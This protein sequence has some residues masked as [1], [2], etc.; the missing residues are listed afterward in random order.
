MTMLQEIVTE[1]TPLRLPVPNSWYALAFSDELP[2]GQVITRRLVGEDVVLYRTQSGQASA[3]NP[4]CPHLGAHL[5]FGGAV[6][7][8]E[9]RCPFHGFRFDLDGTCTATGYGTKPP[10]RAR[11]RLWHLREVN[12]ILFVWYDSQGRP[13]AW[14]IPALDTDGWTQTRHRAFELKDHPQET[15]ENGVDIGHF[16]IVHG[17]SAVEMRSDLVLDG[18]SFQIA[19]AA[20]RPMPVFGRFGAHVDFEFDLNIHG[21]GYSLVKVSVPR[22]NVQTRLFILATPTEQERI[23]LHLA[24][25]MKKLT[26]G[27]QIHPLLFFLPGGWLSGIIGRIVHLSLIH[28]AQQDFAIWENKRYLHPPALAEGDGPIGKFRQWAKQFYHESP[29]TADNGHS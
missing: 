28:D 11:L 17:Y 15:V 9:I 22:Y 4:F 5:G 18:T 23:H 12:G 25:S 13:P 21:L 2:P 8:E 29:L 19:Y 26:S 10:P 6:E 24:L 27:G 1:G 20:R 7:G 14:E 16:A 3:I